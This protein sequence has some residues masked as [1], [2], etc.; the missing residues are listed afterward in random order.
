MWSRRFFRRDHVDVD[1]TALAH[2]PAQRVAFPKACP[3]RAERLAD[4]NLSDVVL[5]G[6]AEQRFADVGAGCGNH[7]R[8]KLACESEITS[9]ACLFF[10]RQLAR[11]FDV[12]HNPRSF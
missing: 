7:F 6:D 8:S 2:E 4:D 9:Q 3:S 1:V 12:G 11:S 5:T 10:L